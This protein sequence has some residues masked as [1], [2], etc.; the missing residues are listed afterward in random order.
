[1][2]LDP[3]PRTHAVEER[4][5][6]S[7]SRLPLKRGFQKPALAGI[8]YAMLM[9]PIKAATAVDGCLIPGPGDMVV[10]MRVVMAT[11]LG[12][13]KVCPLCSLCS[14]VHIGYKHL[15][16]ETKWWK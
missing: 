14:R 4:L 13:C 11:L 10:C 9:K 8:G 7:Q 16:L 12:R 6:C 5:C 1:M 2:L 15:L 3:P